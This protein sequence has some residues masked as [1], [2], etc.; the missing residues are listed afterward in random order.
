MSLKRLEWLGV[1]SENITGLENAT[2]AQ[3]LQKICEAKWTLESEDKDMIVMQH[4]F[5]YLL[6]GKHKQIE[7]FFSCFW[8]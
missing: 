2:P 1:F 5:E 7:F 3:I 6:N 4:Q 8:R